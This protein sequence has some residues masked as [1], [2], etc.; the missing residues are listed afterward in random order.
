MKPIAGHLT[1]LLL[2]SGNQK[3]LAELRSITAPLGV[4]VLSPT[5]IGGLPD[6]EEDG[7]T[8]AAN[9]AKKASAG[10]RYAGLWTLAD[11]SGLTVDALDGAPGVY[12]ARYAGVHGDDEANNARLLKELSAVPDEDR[13][14]SFVCALALARPDSGEIAYET[15]GRT[16][17]EILREAQGE[18]GFGY[19]PLFRFTEPGFPV[20]GMVFARL[21]AEEK[22]SVS[23]R[24]R[25]LRALEPALA[26]LLLARL[27][28]DS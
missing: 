2:A 20:T 1:K 24:G 22:A 28:Q 18:G 5:D 14:A 26:D 10:A 25:A 11:D 8:F 23:H 17:G 3:K 16:F 6:V 27:P 9:A 4:Q 19:D 13:G 15:E 12:S 7:E 21:R